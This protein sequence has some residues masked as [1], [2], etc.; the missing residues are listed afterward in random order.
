MVEGPSREPE[1][2]AG[3][4]TQQAMRTLLSEEA[5]AQGQAMGL[6]QAMITLLPAQGQAM[7]IQHVLVQTSVTAQNHINHIPSL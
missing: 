1:T 7:G 6:Q 4:E 3:T 5:P 2:S